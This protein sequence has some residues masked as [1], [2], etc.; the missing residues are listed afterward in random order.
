MV[1]RLFRGI[2]LQLLWCTIYTPRNSDVICGVLSL[3]LPFVVQLISAIELAL[4]VIEIYVHFWMAASSTRFSSLFQDETLP[5]LPS[6]SYLSYLEKV[7]PVLACGPF[8]G[9]ELSHLACWVSLSVSAGQEYSSIL[10]VM[11]SG[12]D[13]RCSGDSTTTLVPSGGA[14]TE[15]QFDKYV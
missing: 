12:P 8:A 13:S 1:R 3:C 6:S 11:Q 10:Y 2:I 7:L 14:F 4:V 9:C 5:D 15:H